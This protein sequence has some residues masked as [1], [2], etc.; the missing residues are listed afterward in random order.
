MSASAIAVPRDLRAISRA[1]G[2]QVV[3]GQVLAP[4]PEHGP[5]DRS[6]S[7]KLSATS[8]DGFIIHSF[9]GDN[10]RAC[11]DYVLD[12][13]GLP[14][15]G[16]KRESAPAPSPG[17]KV[18]DGGEGAERERAEAQ[19]LWRRRRPIAGSVAERYLREARGYAVEIPPTLAYL[20]PSDAHEP[21]LIAAF[22]MVSEPEPGALA[23]DDADVRAV[24]L[25]KLKQDGSGKADAEPNKI[26]VGRAALGSPIV[27]AP[28]ND[29]LALAI[30]EGLENALSV[31]EATGLGAWA[32][33]GATRMP[34][35]ADAV[36][37]YIECV[38]VFGDDDETGRRHG[39]ELSALLEARGFE[40]LLKVLRGGATS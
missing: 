12:R 37:S 34:A 25:V 33:G 14:R 30:T 15:G 31:C 19:W 26:I 9:A 38:I 7:V 21:A 18:S 27:L 5:G 4:G 3:C 29:L 10:W 20:P 2:G 11:R 13:L 8:P 40:V 6:L 17:P 1:L 16:W 36:P 28:P 39:A 24:Q 23:I 32:S 35:L 22:G